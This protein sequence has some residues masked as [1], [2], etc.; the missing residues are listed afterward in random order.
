MGWLFFT[1][2]L[3]IFGVVLNRINVF[4]VGYNPPYSDQGLLPVDRR[5][6]DDDRHRLQHPVLLPLLRDL[7]PDPAGIRA[8][9]G[10]PARPDARR[11]R[12]D[13]QSI[14]DLG[15]PRRRHRLPAG[16]H[17]AVQRGAHRGHPGLRQNRPGGSARPGAAGAA[18]RARRRSAYPQRPSA[19]KNF[20]LLDSAGAE[21]QGG[22]LRAGGLFA[23]DPRRADGR[24]LRGLPSPLFERRE[25]PRGDGYQRT[26]TRAMEIKLGGPCSSCHDDMA[27]NPPQSCSR[28]HGLP[29]EP[30]ES[31]RASDSRGPTTASASAATNA[32][33]SRRPRPRNAPPAITPG[34]RTTPSWCPSRTSPARRM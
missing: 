14:L 22:R 4:L 29:N 21:D 32:S 2:S 34:R 10:D 19:Y 20:Y 23:P 9:L 6:R 8:G 11:A 15:D 18:P 7:L 12:T 13:R 31:P 1:V 26:C 25:G 17:R 5:D 16:L 27:A 3:I 28:C 30:D 24:G 33:S